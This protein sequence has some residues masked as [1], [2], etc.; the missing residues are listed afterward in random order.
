MIKLTKILEDINSA[1]PNENIPSEWKSFLA[2]NPYSKPINNSVLGGVREF[3]NTNFDNLNEFIQHLQSDRYS[4]IKWALSVIKFLLNQNK[5]NI[6]G[7]Y[8][9]E[10]NDTIRISIILDKNVVV[11]FNVGK[12]KMNYKKDGKAL[13]FVSETEKMME[14]TI[15]EYIR[16][17][18]KKFGFNN[19]EKV[20]ILYLPSNLT[21]ACVPQITPD[22]NMY[23]FYEAIT[24]I[25]SKLIVQL[26]PIFNNIIYCTYEYNVGS[27]NEWVSFTPKKMTNANVV[28]YEILE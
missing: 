17:R 16:G 21:I 20:R 5:C 7:V 2:A 3:Y 11:Y 19:I 10:F 27:G 8:I 23:E 25:G 14:S 22:L 18:F 13:D 6:E 26:K 1:I 12:D 9:S 28:E 15:D 24:A 4:N